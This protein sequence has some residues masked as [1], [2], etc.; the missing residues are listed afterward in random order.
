MVVALTASVSLVAQTDSAWQTTA[1]IEAS[2]GAESKIASIENDAGFQFSVRRGA[3]GR[4]ALCSFR[5]PSSESG[6]LATDKRL[7]VLVDSNQPLAILSWQGPQKSVEDG[8]D[9]MEFRRRASGVVPLAQ[10][11]TDGASFWCWRALKGQAS[12][13]SGLLRQILDG[14]ELTVTLDLG[15]AGT[16]EVEFSLDGA[17]EAIS[18]TLGISPQPAANDIAQEELL[19]FRVNYR[20]TTCYLLQSKKGRKRCLEAVNRCALQTH[21]SVLSMTE[22]VE[23]K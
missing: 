5:V 7:T 21:D 12:P 14:D 2:T 6:S 13:A 23:G 8:D 17:R 3:G 18:D 15:E 19:A 16:R 11:S 22:C 4:R 10:R 1:E 20:S 9:F